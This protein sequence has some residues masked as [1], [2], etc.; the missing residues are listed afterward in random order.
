VP[1]DQNTADIVA[2]IGAAAGLI[3]ILLALLALLRLR[4]MRRDYT[5]LQG[6]DSDGGSFITAVAR[7]V[8]VVEQLRAE[9]AAANSR[10]A[11]LRSD[12]ASAIRHV[13]VVRYDAFGDM[14]GRL[15]FSAAMLDDAGDGLVLTSI[16]GRTE[17]RSYAKGVVAGRSEMTLSP[18][19]EQAIGYAMRGAKAPGR[20]G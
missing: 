4:R 2:I 3:G 8:E 9:L 15:S 13:V 18:E 5:L 20:S 1:L 6:P 7:K 10:I 17:T 12:L 19:E 11:A 16:H 14:G